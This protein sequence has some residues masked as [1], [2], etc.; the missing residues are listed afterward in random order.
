MLPTGLADQ[1]HVL[2]WSD[3]EIELLAGTSA[4]DEACGLRAEADS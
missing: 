3:D 1:N 2:W 4:H